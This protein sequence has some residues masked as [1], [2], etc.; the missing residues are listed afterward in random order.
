MPQSQ[1]IG[2]CGFGPAGPGAPWIPARPVTRKGYAVA[3]GA[4]FSSFMRFPLRI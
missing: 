1:M 4:T 3:T 2:I